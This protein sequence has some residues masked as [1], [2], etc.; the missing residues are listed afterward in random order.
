MKRDHFNRK[1]YIDSNHQFSGAMAVSFREGIL[2]NVCSMFL[3][4]FVKGQLSSDENPVD[5]LL[6]PGWLIGILIMIYYNP[7]IV[8]PVG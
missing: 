3:F 1:K 8:G 5:I 6:N 7:H 2:C 4:V